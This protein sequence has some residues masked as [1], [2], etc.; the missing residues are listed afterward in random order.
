MTLA[1]CFFPNRFFPKAAL[2]I[3]FSKT[4]HLDYLD[5]IYPRYLLSDGLPNN[6]DMRKYC[7]ASYNLNLWFIP[8]ITPFHT[9]TLCAREQYVMH[10][11][12]N[13]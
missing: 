11:L 9:V 13:Y 3:I 4:N 8:E 2:N 10:C 5:R 12:H 7:N 6:F 1:I